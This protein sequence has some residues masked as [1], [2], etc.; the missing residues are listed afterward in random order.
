VIGEPMRRESLS[1]R[2]GMNPAAAKLPVEVLRWSAPRRARRAGQNEPVLDQPDRLGRSGRSDQLGRASA[3]TMPQPVHTMRG[4]KLGTGTSSGHGSTASTAPRWQSQQ[5]T[6]SERAPCARQLPSVIGS[7][8]ARDRG[9][10]GTR[11]GRPQI[12][13]V[14]TS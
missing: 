14:T 1:P 7:W 13:F 9:I 3:P 12:R 11:F 5:L 10:G 6:A 4:P 8:G 2:R